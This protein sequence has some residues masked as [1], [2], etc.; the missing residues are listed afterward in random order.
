MRLHSHV[1]IQQ[2]PSQEWATLWVMNKSCLPLCLKGFFPSL[3]HHPSTSTCH[4]RTSFIYGNLA[5]HHCLAPLA[6]IFI[7]WAYFQDYLCGLL[8]ILL[9]TIYCV[10]SNCERDPSL[11]HLWKGSKYT[12]LVPAPTMK[13]TLIIFSPL[14]Q[15]TMSFDTIC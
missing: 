12:H 8:F 13:G 10:W 6:I 7:R 2:S 5:P 11:L 9:H 14:P 15:I 3:M 1:Y 4:P